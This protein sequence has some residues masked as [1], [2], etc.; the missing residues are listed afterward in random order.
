M[1]SGAGNAV[2]RGA[3]GGVTVK[4]SPGGVGSTRASEQGGD[5]PRSSEHSCAC[6]AP[7]AFYGNAMPPSRAKVTL[8]YEA[9]PLA[10]LLRRGGYGGRRSEGKISLHELVH[11]RGRGSHGEVHR[12]AARGAGGLHPRRGRGRGRD[13]GEDGNQAKH[14]GEC[15]RSD[16]PGSTPPTSWLCQGLG[17]YGR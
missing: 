3:G 6:H 5:I 4:R 10:V 16:W 1:G 7:P 11:V 2:Q 12:R 15:S 9:L 13:G 14:V 17:N 8:Q